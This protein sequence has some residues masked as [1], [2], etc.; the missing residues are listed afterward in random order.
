[1]ETKPKA[2]LAGQQLPAFATPPSHPPINSRLWVGPTRP[3]LEA[4]AEAI[5]KAAQDSDEPGN[6]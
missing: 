6:K 1:M 5:E 2:P 3:S 4:L